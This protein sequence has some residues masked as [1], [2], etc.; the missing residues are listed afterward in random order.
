M[1]GKLRKQRYLYIRLTPDLLTH[2]VNFLSENK[3]TPASENML[4]YISIN[5]FNTISVYY[6][7][8]SVFQKNEHEFYGTFALNDIFEKKNAEKCH[9]SICHLKRMR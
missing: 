5:F 8:V 2:F 3:Y 6:F 7:R 4:V 9:I 1:N